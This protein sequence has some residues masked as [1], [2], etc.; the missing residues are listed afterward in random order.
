LEG[1][2]EADG[3]GFAASG[4]APSGFGFAASG[5][6]FAASGFDLAFSVSVRFRAFS[7]IRWAS[8]SLWFAILSSSSDGLPTTK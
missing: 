6:G 4:F 8:L 2:L 7:M 3:R 5:F 1:S